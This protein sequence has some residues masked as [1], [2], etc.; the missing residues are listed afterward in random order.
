MAQNTINGVEFE[1]HAREEKDRTFTGCWTCL[2]CRTGGEA[3]SG[4]LE[5][6]LAILDAR[7]AA[8]SHAGAHHSEMK[9]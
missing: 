1:I 2:K 6:G 4:A 8:S 5:A 3:G 9:N 7:L